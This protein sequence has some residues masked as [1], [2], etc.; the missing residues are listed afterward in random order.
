MKRYLYLI[1][2]MPLLVACTSGKTEF[3][4]TQGYSAGAAEVTVIRERRMF[5]MGFS[6]EVFFDDKVIARLKTGQYVTFYITPGVHNIGIPNQSIAAVLDRGRKHYFVITTDSSQ[7][8]FEIAQI[9]E[10]EAASL[11][12]QAK[13]IH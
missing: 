4:P 2:L 9:S 1:I 11:M 10:R 13:S 12:A 3:F 8:G 7:F 5:G 6:M